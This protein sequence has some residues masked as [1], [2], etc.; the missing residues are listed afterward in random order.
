MRDKAIHFVS[1]LGWAALVV[2]VA[3]TAHTTAGGTVRQYE[4]KLGMTPDQLAAYVA[5][6]VLFGFVG[7]VI[8][9]AFGR[10]HGY[11]LGRREHSRP[12]TRVE[13]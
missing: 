10:Y 4:V 13:P 5:G 6:G 1:A 12:F 3:W 7:V 2:Y 8:G 11:T 9:W